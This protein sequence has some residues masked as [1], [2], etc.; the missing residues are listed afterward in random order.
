MRILIRYG[1]IGLKSA[2]VQSKLC[3]R[4]KESL[5]NHLDAQD[6]DGS[7]IERDDRIFA[8][9]EDEAAADAVLALSKVPG[10]VSVSPVLE[11]GEAAMDALESKALDAVTHEMESYSEDERPETFAIDARRA[12]EHEFTSKDIEN[13]VGDAVRK[14]F[15]LDVDL[16]DPDL[17]VGIE[18]RYTNTYIYTQTVTGIGGLPKEERKK[19]VVLME[20]RAA[21]VASYRLMKRGCNVFPVYTGHEADKLDEDMDT[22][23][24]FDPDVK[25]TVMKGKD[26]AEA[27]E[28][29]CDIFEANAVALPY[30]AEELDEMDTPNID[31]ELLYPN[32]GMSEE[33]VMD[34]YAEILYHRL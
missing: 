20:D 30:T 21:T 19:V 18:V 17:T 12:G 33:T 32:A 11:A 28:A 8:D 24:Q 27:L 34:Q 14:Q 1:E 10:V 5:Q 3:D 6:I 31:A 2:Q 26:D 29:A 25:L 16:D 7:I 13:R 4:L 9:V 22:L 23:R 15:G